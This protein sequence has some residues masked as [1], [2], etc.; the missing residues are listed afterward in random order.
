MKFQLNSTQHNYNK[1]YPNI[2][3]KLLECLIND[4]PDNLPRKY[5]T[6]FELG[7]LVG[8]QEVIDKLKIEKE[9]NENKNLEE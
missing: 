7:V 2:S 9:Y 4:F 1:D 8:H 5:L 3:D 6:E